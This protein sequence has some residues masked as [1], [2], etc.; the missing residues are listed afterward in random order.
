MLHLEVELKPIFKR[1][2]RPDYSEVS[3]LNNK[4]IE[5]AL[6][7]GAHRL[8]RVVLWRVLN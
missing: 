6:F 2:T 5:S 3:N 4:L 7:Y 8:R 1:G